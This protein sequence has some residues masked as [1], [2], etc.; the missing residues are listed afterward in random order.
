ML[1]LAQAGPV[2]ARAGQH[3]VQL[4]H[5]HRAISTL[6]QLGRGSSLGAG[7]GVDVW[8][9]CCGTLGC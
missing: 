9:S 5:Q 6:Q 1:G 4:C 7:Q 8:M 3:P 2:G